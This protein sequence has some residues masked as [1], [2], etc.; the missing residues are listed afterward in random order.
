MAKDIIDVHAHVVFDALLGAAGEHGP[1]VGLTDQGAP[2]FRIGGYKMTPI[3]YEGTVFTDLS[4]RLLELDRLNID[5]QVL[6]N[7]IHL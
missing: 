4:L 2:F 7:S 6:T 1:E 3:T 5:I